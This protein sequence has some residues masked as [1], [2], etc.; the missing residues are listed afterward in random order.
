VHVLFDGRVFPCC[1]PY[2]HRKMQIGDL[3]RQDFA[4]IWNGRLLRNL[5]A[6]LKSGDVPAICRG[7]SAVHDPPPRE[8]PERLAASPDL[9]RH[10]QER[11]LDP[12]AAGDPRAGLQSSGLLEYVLDLRAH[13][14]AL[15]RERAQLAAHARALEAELPALRGHL[16]TLERLGTDVSRRDNWLRS[17]RRTARSLRFLLRTLDTRRR[18]DGAPTNGRGA[19]P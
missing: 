3:R 15:E 18:D 14:T 4:A 10:Y 8:D 11:D 19:T 9:T 17:P 16:T 7:C 13:A 2:A 5:R 12:L 1:H 6:G